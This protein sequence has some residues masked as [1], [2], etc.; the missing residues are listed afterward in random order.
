MACCDSARGPISG[1][2]TNLEVISVERSAALKNIGDIVPAD[3]ICEFCEAELTLETA[4]QNAYGNC[5]SSCN[6]K[7]QDFVLGETGESSV[8]LKVAELVTRYGD[9]SY[10]CGEH[11]G[12]RY[13]DCVEKL[14]DARKALMQF[15]YESVQK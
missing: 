4:V 11:S 12:E 9:A 3:I 10:D 14:R 1:E 7:V 5:C 13:E 15:V 8:M 6:R 2:G